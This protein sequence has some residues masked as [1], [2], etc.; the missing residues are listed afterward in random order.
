MFS[1]HVELFATT[2]SSLARPIQEAKQRHEKDADD[3]AVK[4]DVQ[5]IIE[6]HFKE[7]KQ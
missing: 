3:P 7:S 6:D 1:S 5:L 2:D 4:A